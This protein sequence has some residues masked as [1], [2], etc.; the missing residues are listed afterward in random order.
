[1]ASTQIS[2]KGRLRR[3]AYL[4][5]ASSPP[6]TGFQPYSL[7]LGTYDGH[8]FAGFLSFL[9]RKDLE[10]ELTSLRS[11]SKT[12]KG[13][14]GFPYLVTSFPHCVPGIVT[15]FEAGKFH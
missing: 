2:E 4:E 7:N 5:E 15:I 1:M 14:M 6:K 9:D 8:G 10:Q 13:S 12:R 3:N 11:V